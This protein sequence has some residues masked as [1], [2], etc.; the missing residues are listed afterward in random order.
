MWTFENLRLN[1]N[2]ISIKEWIA[3]AIILVTVNLFFFEKS[4]VIE[5]KQTIDAISSRDIPRR[6]D[7]Y[8]NE[9]LTSII[10]GDYG[11][12]SDMASYYSLIGEYDKDFPWRRVAASAGDTTEASIIVIDLMYDGFM[13]DMPNAA[14]AEGFSLLNK[15]AKTDSSIFNELNKYKK[16]YQAKWPELP[17]PYIYSPEAEEK[18]TQTASNHKNKDALNNHANPTGIS[19]DKKSSDKVSS[20]NSIINRKSDAD[21]NREITN[22]INGDYIRAIDMAN[23]YRSIGEHDKYLPWMRVA[24][25]AGDSQAMVNVAE[26]LLRKGLVMDKPDTS[27]AEGFILL[28]NAAKTDF[29]L[30]EKLNKY[31]EKYKT[32]WPELPSPYVSRPE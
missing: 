30:L 31:K 12:G 27:V 8:I 16:E 7:E 21:I 17:P 15:I 26:E 10:N 1:L 6:S 23:Y 13:E 5:N 9:R 19:L 24:A 28:N 25:S 3:F 22:I 14:I 4:Q 11:L 20:T 32:K 2:K 18:N 29:S